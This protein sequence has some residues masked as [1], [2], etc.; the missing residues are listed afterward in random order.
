M[1]VGIEKMVGALALAVV[2]A[3]TTDAHGRDRI[4][5]DDPQAEAERA[6]IMREGAS[7]HWTAVPKDASRPLIVWSRL[8]GLDIL[9]HRTDAPR[10]LVRITMVGRRGG[11]FEDMERIREAVLHHL[12]VRKVLSSP[13]GDPADSY[14]DTTREPQ[15]QIL[16]QL[17]SL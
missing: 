10:P 17:Q 3:A 6:R 13:P 7:V 8:D 12:R 16:V 5:G 15:V 14:S 1:S 2:D 9:G 4:F 11:S